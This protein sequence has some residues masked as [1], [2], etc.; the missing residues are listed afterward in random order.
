[1]NK[2]NKAI[3]LSALLSA[4]LLAG[5][6]DK[7]E[8]VEIDGK[9]YVKNGEEYI[10][11][12]EKTKIFEPG[13]HYIHYYNYISY[14]NPDRQSGFS[15]S[16]NVPVLEGYEVFSVE[17]VLRNGYTYG[18]MYIFVNTQRVEAT[19]SYDYNKNEYYFCNPGVLVEEHKLS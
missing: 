4:T 9:N 3:I 13:T 17:P 15:D 10:E 12:F 8:V 19:A 11:V 2:K 5:C 16:Y 7:K 6:D 1:M 18:Y 14:N